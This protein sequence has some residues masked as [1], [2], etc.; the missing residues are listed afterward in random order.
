MSQIWC[1][2]KISSTQITETQF[3]C[4][5]TEIKQPNIRKLKS[6]LMPLQDIEWP[7]AQPP[8][9]ILFQNFQ[10][11]NVIRRKFKTN[12]NALVITDKVYSEQHTRAGWN[13]KP[14]TKYSTQELIEIYHL[15]R[16]WNIVGKVN[17]VNVTCK[18]KF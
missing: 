8:P 12:Q 6:Y 10:Y 3:E 11:A 18:I 9:K 15:R 4:K 14:L 13:I 1:T 2:Q 5:S 16:R 17:L 7:S